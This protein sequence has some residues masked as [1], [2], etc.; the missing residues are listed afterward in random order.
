MYYLDDQMSPIGFVTG[1]VDHAL[2]W[3]WRLGHPF[4]QK[5]RSVVSF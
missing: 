5:L 3:H 1:Q 4:V 2:L